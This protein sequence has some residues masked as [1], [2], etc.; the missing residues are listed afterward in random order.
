MKLAIVHDYLNQYGGAEKVV[1]AMHEIWP[2]APIYTSIYDEP[3][4]REWGFKSRGMDIRTSYMQWLLPLLRI[5]PRYYFTFA[6]NFAFRLFNLSGY[7]VILSSASY[8]AKDIRKPTKAIH[9]SYIHTPPR[10]LYGYDQETNIAKMN[11]FERTLAR[12]WKVYLKYRD[13]R[14]VR[15]IDFLI[16]NSQT[17][18]RRIRQAY[19]R[20][21]E[22]INPPIEVK[23]FA[24]KSQNEGYF[25]VVSRLGEYKKVDLVV[26]AFN[27]LRLPL[28]VV[29]SGPQF[30]YLKEIAKDNVEILGRL[31]EKETVKLMMG[32][33]AFVFPTEEDFGI[34]PVEAM[35]AGKPVIA[36]GVGGATET[37]IDGK[38]GIFFDEQTVESIIRVVKT[39][40]P[41][42]F[43]SEDCR[44][45]A[46]KFDK[47]IF[48]AKIKD[49]VTQAVSG[50][51]TNEG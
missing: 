48:Q 31:P 15:G 46:K 47:A 7:D 22:V 39:F 2:D 6:Y 14:A 38:T 36:Y 21:S 40:D 20:Q 9:I 42:K 34:T 30:N 3:Q 29:G 5:L 13:Q 23:K 10:F 25:L 16:A 1:E 4:M 24:G 18:Q 17:V 12:V 32:C 41:S 49:F 43:K 11:L 19:H 26:K 44:R 35:A 27:E 28:K 51:I 45:Q 50:K 37:V 33:T 8:A